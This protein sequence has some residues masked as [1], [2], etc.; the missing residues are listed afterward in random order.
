MRLRCVSI[1]PFGNPVVPDEYGGTTTSVEGL[2]LTGGGSASTD[3]D[4]ID[5][6]PTA[7]SI[8]RMS[9]GIE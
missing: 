1:T 2:I 8:V 5:N 4:A 3:I 7:S 6:S 9:I